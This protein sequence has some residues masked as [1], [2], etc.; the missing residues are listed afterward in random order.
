[1]AAILFFAGAGVVVMLEWFTQDRLPPG[2]FAGYAAVI[3][4]V[5][6][7]VLRNGQVPAWCSTCFGGSTYF[8]S[9]FKEYAALALSA[10]LEPVLATKL[11][12]LITKVLAAFGVY[13]VLARLFGAPEAGIVAGYACVFGAFANYET[14]LDEPISLTLFPLVFLASVELLRRRRWPWAVGLGVLLACQLS[15]NAVQALLCPVMFGLLL[16]FRPWRDGPGAE[17]PFGDRRLA[18]RWAMLTALT[19]VVFLVVAAS[20]LA[21]LAADLHHHSLVRPAAVARD[22]ERL[23]ERSPFLYLNRGNWMAPWLATHQ[24]PGLNIVEVDGERHYLGVLVLAVCLGGWFPARRTALR[25][26]YQV[27][28]LLLLVQYWLSLGPRTLVWQVVQSFHRGD[29]ESPLHTALTAGA[30]ACLAGA[31]LLA[32]RPARAGARICTPRIELLLGLALVL[33]FCSHSLGE[34]TRRWLP[35]VGSLL[36]LQRSPGHFFDLAPFSLA[37]LFGLALVALRPLVPRRRMW[38]GLTA[39]LAGL[40]VIDFWPSRDAFLRGTPMPTVR[41]AERMLAGVPGE[42]GTLR[43]TIGPVASPLGSLLATSSEPG[44]AYAWLSWQAGRYWLPFLATAAWSPSGGPL[45]ATGRI[46]YFLLESEEP[47][48]LAEPWELRARSGV[49]SLWE[50]PEVAPFASAYHRYVVFAGEPDELVLPLVADAFGHGM[51]VLSVGPRLSD[52]AGGVLG[53]AAIVACTRGALLSDE[54]SRTLATL[55]ADQLVQPAD[56]FGARWRE[57][58]ATVPVEPTLEVSFTRS[59]SERIALRANTGPAAAVILVSESYHPWWK[60]TVDGVATPVLR[61]QMTL[62]AIPV[63]PGAHEIEMRLRRPP[64]VAAADA[65]TGFAWVG[66]GAGAAAY[67]VVRWRQRR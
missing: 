25:R 53:G 64:A 32:M 23:I 62:M 43:V 33:F 35:L 20:P 56:V 29:L 8:V 13:L 9:S 22:R 2:D 30:V 66:L 6:N 12:F 59:A 48:V 60:A 3:R 58:M 46:K 31:A 50:Q 52:A 47:R 39:A 44:W 10:W 51:P 4:F 57:L 38:L 15:N 24:P 34:L 45:L 19:L 36:G 61:A 55:Y 21:W 67:G 40:V 14:H 65:V 28:T 11:M 27:A 41:E 37:L 1:M 16:A 49:F 5:R 7:A 42:G 18:V 26:W 63:G 54:A 17:N